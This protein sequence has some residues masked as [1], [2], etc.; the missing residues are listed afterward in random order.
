MLGRGYVSWA[1]KY[2]LF[3]NFRKWVDGVGLARKCTGG[4]ILEWHWVTLARFCFYSVFSVLSN[5]PT[6]SVSG[7]R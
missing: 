5:M 2:V 1:Q 4:V 3:C 6:V 7:F